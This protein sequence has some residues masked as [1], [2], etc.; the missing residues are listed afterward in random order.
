LSPQG[1]DAKIAINKFVINVPF[2]LTALSKRDSCQKSGERA[3]FKEAED[4][5]NFH[6]SVAEF[7]KI[8]RRDLNAN[9]HQK[10]LLCNDIVF[11]EFCC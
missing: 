3:R 2:P 6:R 8:E 7:L 1:D 11:S 10:R 5:A 4:G 9:T